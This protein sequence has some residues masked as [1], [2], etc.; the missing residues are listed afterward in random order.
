MRCII[1]PFGGRVRSHDGP[2]LQHTRF[3]IADYQ[4]AAG[5]PLPVRPENDREGGKMAAAAGRDARGAFNLRGMAARKSGRCVFLCVLA[6]FG[7]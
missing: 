2:A 7:F 1:Q 3:V 5:A 6:R 4:P